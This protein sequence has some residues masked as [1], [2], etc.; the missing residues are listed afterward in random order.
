VVAAVL[1]ALNA[2]VGL[3]GDVEDHT[4]GLGAA[5]EVTAGLAFLAGAAALA[6]LRPVGGWRG[7]LWSLAP[8]GLVVSGLTMVGVPLVGAEPAEWLFV[9][10]VLPTFVGLVATG[11]LGARRTWGWPTGVGLALLLPIMFLAPLNSLLMA[12]VWSSVALNQRR[13]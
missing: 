12:A 11:V 7:A 8:A 1:L 6:L 5:S 3:I 2:A 9:I 4:T 13:R 10:A